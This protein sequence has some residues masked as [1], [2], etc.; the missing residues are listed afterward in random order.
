MFSCP[1]SKCL[2]E[3]NA[4]IFSPRPGAAHFVF[5]MT[6]NSVSPLVFLWR[7]ILARWVVLCSAAK[8]FLDKCSV[9]DGS[10]GSWKW[11]VI[12]VLST[13]ISFLVVHC[14]M[15]KHNSLTV[16]SLRHDHCVSS[17][18]S[19][20]D[21]RGLREMKCVEWSIYEAQTVTLRG[22]GHLLM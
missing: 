11:L 20:T 2:F 1:L 15:F 13:T 22:C 21:C 14:Y 7:R 3:E 19:C 6:R 9:L 5:L 18:I 8:C 12:V 16:I 10:K 4:V 17:P